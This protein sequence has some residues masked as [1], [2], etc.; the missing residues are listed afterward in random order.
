MAYPVSGFSLLEVV[1]S[2][3]IFVF[4]SGSVASISSIYFD[5]IR[6]LEETLVLSRE[7]RMVH[8]SLAQDFSLARGIQSI[9]PEEILFWVDGRDSTEPFKIAR[10]VA[11][12]RSLWRIDPADSTPQFIGRGVTGFGY[13]CRGKG[14]LSLKFNFESGRL[15][16]TVV[17][18][19]RQVFAVPSTP[20][21][22]T[23]DRAP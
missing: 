15:R 11:K 13:E 10:Y 8:D 12:G 16:E 4:L 21:G 9:G 6:S 14:G 22:G 23:D 7:I 3:T 19:V 20:S 18:P 1:I 2:S 5:H 17:F